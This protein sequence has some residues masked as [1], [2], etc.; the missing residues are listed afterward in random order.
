MKSMGLTAAASSVAGNVTWGASALHSGSVA[1]PA[2]LGG[3]PVRQQ[4][5][6]AWP[7]QGRADEDIMIKALQEK[8]WCYLRSGAHFCRD[9]EETLRRD[10]DGAHVL[11]TNAGTTALHACLYA[12]DVGPGDEVLVTGDSFIATMQAI[13]NLFALPIFVDVDPTTGLMDPRLIEQAIT[14]HT[15]AIMPVHLFGASCDMDAVMRIAAKH[16]LKVIEDAC[17][18]PYVEWDGR[19]LGTIGDCGALSFNV[20]KTLGCGEGGLIISAHDEV[21]H[22]CD[23][24]RN[25][26]RTSMSNEGFMGMNYRPTEF[27]AALLVTQTEQYKQQAP[28][29]R[30][31]AA[32]LNQGLAEIP[33]LDPLRV[34]PQ[35]KYH[36]YYN[37]I[38]RYDAD[39]WGGLPIDK[40]TSAMRAE[41][42]PCGCQPDA[43]TMSQHHSLDRQLQS[44]H[45]R[46][47]CTP[48]QL[49]RCEASRAC[50]QALHL[51]RHQVQFSQSLLLG[52]QADMD[53]ILNAARKIHSHAQALAKT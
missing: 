29:R 2:L 23:A 38:V 52:T 18:S 24:F 36:N 21:A 9:Y 20:W 10:Y 14:P 41:G 37:Y 1:R 45:F 15:K 33:G 35:T 32:H 12:M 22:A 50:P 25:N 19:K 31:N 42:I 30:R 5:W 13:L 8:R 17:Q 27:Q 44:R 40:F 26:G 16:G 28:I 4:S 39:A 48:E 3:T 7:Q 34:L 11:L 47:I 43:R 6:P 46:K 49:Q 51:A 53:D